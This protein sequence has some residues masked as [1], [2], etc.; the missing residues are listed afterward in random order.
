[1]KK[2]ALP[3]IKWFR[4]N[5]ETHGILTAVL[6]KKNGLRPNNV[7][8][9]YAQ[10]IDE[11]RDFRLLV[12]DPRDPSKPFAHPVI[13]FANYHNL[14]T[15]ES[16]HQITYEATFPLP[17]FGYFGYFIQFTFDGPFNTVNIITTETNV[18][19]ETFPFPDCSGESCYGKL[20]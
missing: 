13:W 16:S 18:I 7:V 6:D 9:Y 11:R 10:T 20:V 19:P 14:K 3:K 1:M 15:S 17:R 8:I 2:Q 5:N 4:N 12:G